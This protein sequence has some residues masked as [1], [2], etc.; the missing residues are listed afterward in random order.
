MPEPRAETSFDDLADIYD[1]LVDWPR[2]LSNEEPFFKRLFAEH[3][4]RCVLDVACGTGHHAAMFHSWGL[5]VCGSDISPAMIARCRER[6][7]EPAGLRWL[8][9]SFED[10]PVVPGVFDAVTC[11]GNSLALAPNPACAG[12]AVAAMLDALR[13][14]GVGLVQ[15]LNIWP[16]PDGALDWQKTILRQTPEG[17][18][19]TLKGLRRHGG[20]GI[21]ELVHLN[22]RGDE[23]VPRFDSRSFLGLEAEWLMRSVVESGGESPRCLGGYHGETFDKTRSQDLLVLFRRCE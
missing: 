14:G 10:P 18:T 7:G 6:F 21:V 20:R 15:L 22:L 8:V 1:L 2:R 19:I 12:R 4:V 17:A 23:L 13:P 9:R 16:R 11:L 5:E 3:G